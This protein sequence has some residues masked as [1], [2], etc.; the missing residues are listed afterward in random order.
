MLIRPLYSRNDPNWKVNWFFLHMILTLFVR[1]G[2]ASRCKQI[3]YPVVFVTMLHHLYSRS[4]ICW[5]RFIQSVCHGACWPWYQISLGFETGRTNDKDIS[6]ILCVSNATWNHHLLG[7]WEPQ[8]NMKH[9]VTCQIPRYV[10]PKLASK[11][12]RC[13]GSCDGFSRYVSPVKR[14][15]WKISFTFIT[16]LK[17]EMG[18]VALERGNYF[19]IVSVLCGPFIVCWHVLILILAICRFL[20]APIFELFST[21]FCY[22]TAAWIRKLLLNDKKS[23]WGGA[24]KVHLSQRR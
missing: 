23:I 18:N 17:F 12:E 3:C 24:I 13:H 11:P 21:L 15:T 8:S 10:W 7:S 16:F 5:V 2:L 4:L 9:G 20:N 19:R 14:W 22:S 1:M 6:S